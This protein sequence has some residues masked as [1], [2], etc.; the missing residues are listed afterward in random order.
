MFQPPQCL[1][2]SGNIDEPTAQM[3]GLHGNRQLRPNGGTQKSDP[4]RYFDIGCVEYGVY[5][6]ALTL[7]KS[8]PKTATSRGR[9]FSQIAAD[10]ARQQAEIQCRGVSW[11]RLAAESCISVYQWPGRPGIAPG[12]RSIKEEYRV[13]VLV[14]DNNVDQAL[15]VLKKKMQREGVFREMKLHG[16]YEKPSERRI[17]EKSEAI[18]RAR[19][20][21]RKK[22]QREGLLPMKPRVAQ[23]AVGRNGPARPSRF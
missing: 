13:Q 3:W 16:H 23:G 10:C 2:A 9:L 20:L 7:P 19:K 15:K 8:C 4:N 21:A 11:P 12:N 1:P 18:R 14:R 6:Q 5:A 22:L 17:R